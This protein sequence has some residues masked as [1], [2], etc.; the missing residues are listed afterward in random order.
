MARTPSEAVSFARTAAPLSDSA[1]GL[2]AGITTPLAGVERLLAKK[3]IKDALGFTAFVLP[4]NDAVW[5][6]CL[7]AWHHVRPTPP[8]LEAHA[9]RA[10]LHWMQKPG[11]PTR[12]D[13]EVAAQRAGLSTPAG[14]MAQAV[15]C[16]EGSVSRPGL[17]KVLASPALAARLVLTGLRLAAAREKNAQPEDCFEV[18]VRMARPTLQRL[19]PAAPQQS[20]RA[21]SDT[22]NWTEEG[23]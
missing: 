23:E 15:F 16:S 13:A 8:P 18:Y 2:L 6:G 11:E 9:F 7:C 19:S 20:S 17:P 14:C 1:R 10:V 5:W 12:R 22:S 4:I 3:R 21:T